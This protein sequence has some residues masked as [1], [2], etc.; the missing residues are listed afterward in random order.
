[1]ANAEK[2]S[3]DAPDETRRTPS[4]AWILSVTNRAS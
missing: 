2:K 4:I 3:L 1:M